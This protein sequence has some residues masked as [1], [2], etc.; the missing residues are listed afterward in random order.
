MSTF[1]A[2]HTIGSSIRLVPRF[3]EASRYST[4]VRFP[5]SGVC[6][7][8]V[9]TDFCTAF[10]VGCNRFERCVD[11][12]LVLDPRRRGPCPHIDL[13]EVLASDTHADKLHLA[14]QEILE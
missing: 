10:A 1:L 5:V 9:I 14:R 3:D 4:T 8:G 2:L 13:T 6:E 7:N 11:I 12:R